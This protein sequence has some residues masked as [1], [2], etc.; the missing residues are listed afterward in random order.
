MMKQLILSVNAGSSSVKLSLV[1]TSKNQTIWQETFNYKRPEQVATQFKTDVVPKLHNLPVTEIIAVAH[2]VVD[3]GTI[4]VQEI[5]DTWMSWANGQQ[6]HAP[7]HL[8][9]QLEIIAIMRQL[10]PATKHIAVSDNAQI[11]TI[12]VEQTC[13]CHSNAIA[14]KVPVI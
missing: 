2:R 6:I 8:P 7:L 1:D 11:C 5:D 13:I 12:A 14:G 10:L 3:G 9:I 4:E